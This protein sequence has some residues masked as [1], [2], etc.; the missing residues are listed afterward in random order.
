VDFEAQTTSR[1]RLEPK[2]EI[3]I[4]KEVIGK[5]KSTNNVLTLSD[6][7]L[8][9]ISDQLDQIGVALAE[10]FEPLDAK[11][12]QQTLKLHGKRV[13]AV[14][15]ITQLASEYG[16]SAPGIQVTDISANMAAATK[17][18]GVLKKVAALHK[19]L[20][21]QVLV[22]ESNAWKGASTLYGVLQG[23]AK[24]NVVLKQALQPIREQ[25][26]TSKKKKTEQA[27]DTAVGTA[28]ETKS[29]T[30]ATT[31]AKAAAAQTTPTTVTATTAG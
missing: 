16:I 6:K 7:E 29:T 20:G 21:D 12:A 27:T 26:R 5:M 4:R 3:S 11:Q 10:G 13:K 24:S 19:V 25:L 23:N 14:S 30:D 15:D 31:T 1:T 9:T 17:L 18:R 22:A 2:A 8:S 28:A